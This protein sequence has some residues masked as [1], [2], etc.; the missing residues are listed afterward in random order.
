MDCNEAY[1][2]RFAHQEV[3]QDYVDTYYYS[4]VNS[5][6]CRSSEKMSPAIG[7][8]TEHSSSHE[9]DEDKLVQNEAYII[10][11]QSVIPVSPNAAYDSHQQTTNSRR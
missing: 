11:K 8:T 6:A 4:E 2:R 3:G 1:T 10:Y 7:A 9:Y 5:I